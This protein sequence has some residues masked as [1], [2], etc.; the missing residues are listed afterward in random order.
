MQDP[1]IAAV[2]GLNL[3]GLRIHRK[4]PIIF[5]CGGDFKHIPARSVRGRLLEYL[6]HKNSPLHDSIKIADNFQDWLNDSVY[7]DLT[8]FETDIG[9]ISSLIA[10][11]LESPGALVELGLFVK[12]TICR[13][14]S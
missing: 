2:Q 13:P 10:I 12:D 4:P 1:R 9:G 7:A 14:H 6:K 8:Q 11:V 5:L 3:H